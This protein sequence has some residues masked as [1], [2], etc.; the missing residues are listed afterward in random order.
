MKDVL[1]FKSHWVSTYAKNLYATPEDFEQLFAKQKIELLRLSLQL[2]VNAAKAEKCLILAM[3]DCLSRSTVSKDRVRTWARRMVI[4]NAIRLVWEMP[5]E[6]ADE[7]GFEF[8][9]QPSGLPLEALQDSVEILTLP[10]LDRMAFVICVLERY[11]I[12]DCALLVGKSPQEVYEAM[13]R[14]KRRL[15]PVELRSHD[16]AAA[17]LGSMY[18]FHRGQATELA[19]SCGS[20]FDRLLHRSTD[21]AAG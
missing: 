9:L 17:E 21:D 2:T 16:Q 18:G 5:N 12:L 6:L 3:R 20:I 1:Q 15:L 14:A 4:R 7:S 8:Q 11:S 13:V 10:N 19:G